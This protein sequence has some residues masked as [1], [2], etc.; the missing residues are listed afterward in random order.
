[1]WVMSKPRL[2][3]YAAPMKM[4]WRSRPVTRSLPAD[5]RLTKSLTLWGIAGFVVLVPFGVLLVL[6]RSHSSGLQDFDQSVARHLHDLVIDHRWLVR[7]LDDVSTVGAPRT[8]WILTAVLALVLLIRRAGRLAL[9]AG[10]TMAGA[11]LLDNVIK[12]LA[13]RA[14][15]LF[16]DPVASAPGKSFPSGHALESLTGVLILLAVLLPVLR[17]LWRAV[18]IALATLV[19]ATIGFARVTLG[20]HY[21]SDV[22]G[23]WIFAI[24]WFVATAAAFRIWRKK[25]EP[26][27]ETGSL[28]PAGSERLVK[29]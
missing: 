16:S 17:P 9:W 22:L 8:F 14:R 4:R 7:V 12:T 2:A 28:D 20:V 23:G 27:T 26:Y 15:P 19:V 11:A 5:S 25:V 24:G 18:A 6:V 3:G 21:L 29:S 10:V 1:M 13:D